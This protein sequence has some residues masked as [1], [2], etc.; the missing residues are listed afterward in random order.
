MDLQIQIF[1]CK[2]SKTISDI[3]LFKKNAVISYV[4]NRFTGKKTKK[5]RILLLQKKIL[6]V[7]KKKQ[8]F[9]SRLILKLFEVFEV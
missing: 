6:K 9:K 1:I 5:I 7:K 8:I 2:C 3:R 4:K